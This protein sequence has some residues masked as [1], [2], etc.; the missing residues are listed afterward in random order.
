MIY[1]VF[2]LER[3]TLIILIEVEIDLFSWKDIEKILWRRYFYCGLI[4]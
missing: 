1:I 2:S 3:N 4:N